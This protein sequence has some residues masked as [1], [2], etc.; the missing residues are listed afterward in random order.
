MYFTRLKDLRSD[1]DL[2]QKQ[3][4]NV[5]EIDPRVYSIYEIGKCEIP[6]CYIIKLANYYNV[7]TDYI[8]GLTNYTSP[9]LKINK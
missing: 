6:I 1:N 3:V 9:V 2:L 4:A 8:L 7:S 5:L